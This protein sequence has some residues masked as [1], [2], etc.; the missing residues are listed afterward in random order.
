MK[1]ALQDQQK[2]ERKVAYYHGCYVN[3]NNPQLGKEFLKV[4]NAM[5]IGVMLLEKEKCCGL[6][7]MVNG[8]PERARNIAQFN[9]DYIGKMVDENGLDVISEASSCS[10]NLRDEYHHV[11]GIDNAKVRPH[12]HMVT[13]FLYQLFKEGKTLPLKPLKLRVAYHTACHVDKAGWAPYTLEVLKKIPG[14]EIIML[15]SQCCGIAGTYGF[16]SE[17]YEVS[18]SIG[19]TL[20]DNIN[21]GGFDYVISECQTCK[22]QIDMSSNVTCIHPLTLL[23]MSMDA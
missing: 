12:I 2:F 9:T 20:F 15:P 8:F 10:L 11:L 13:P 5:N 19:K 14:L 23:C 6:P 16:K 4:F 1:N 7:L 21:E 3:Y 22:W 17:N 18:Q